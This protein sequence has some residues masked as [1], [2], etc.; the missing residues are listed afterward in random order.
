MCKHN[1]S[2]QQPPLGAAIRSATKPNRVFSLRRSLATPDNSQSPEFR[3]LGSAVLSLVV[4]LGGHRTVPRECH[5]FFRIQFPIGCR[6]DGKS[7]QAVAGAIT[8]P[9]SVHAALINF[10]ISFSP[11]GRLGFQ[12]TFGCPVFANDF[13]RANVAE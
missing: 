4:L 1:R 6:R 11:T 3:H 5:R 9:S 13:F 7:S 2:T 12:R 10:P 8:R